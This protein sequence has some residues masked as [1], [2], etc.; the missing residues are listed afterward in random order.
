MHPV[1]NRCLQGISLTVSSSSNSNK[2]TGHFSPLSVKWRKSLRKV[3]EEWHQ[4]FNRS[5]NTATQ[6]NINLKLLSIIFTTSCYVFFN[7]ITFAHD[8]ERVVCY[9]LVQE[10]WW[11]QED[12][13]PQLLLQEEGDAG[14][15][16]TNQMNPSLCQ[17]PASETYSR[18]VCE[19]VSS[20]ISFSSTWLTKTIKVG[21]NIAVN[22]NTIN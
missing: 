7:A 13:E 12:S 5:I 22:A 15:N 3:Q 6:G 4:G 18:K 1:W 19:M 17:D 20:V 21:F 10:R 2:H 16:P 8:H 14:P 11:P 9:L